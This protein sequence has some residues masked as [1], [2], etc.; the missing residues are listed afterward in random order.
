M[1]FKF[2]VLIILISTIFLNS[3]GAKAQTENQVNGISQRMI[4]P[5]Y[6][7]PSNK[8]AAWQRVIDSN[9]YK[10]IDVI[11]NPN[12]G[13]GSSIN[14]DYLEAIKK[15]K[16]GS[17]NVFG[18]VHTSYGDR[19]IDD[20]KKEID[21]WV[22]WYPLIDGIFID[23]AEYR[24]SQGDEPYYLEVYNYIK[25]KGLKSM[26]NPGTGTTESYISLADSTCIF[27]SAVSKAFVFP[28]W[29]YKYDSDKFCYLGHSA[30]LESMRSIVADLKIKKVK[31]V[32]I[33]DATPAVDFW[34]YLPSYLEEEAAL[35]YY[36]SIS[37]TNTPT[38]T[39]PTPSRTLTPTI[40]RTPTKTFTPIP[41][42]TF[43]KTPTL[44]LS[45]TPFSPTPTVNSTFWLCEQ[46]GSQMTCVIYP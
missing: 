46:Q 16:A 37:Q 24:A 27:E 31:N 42:K 28:S 43:T 7:Y 21:T 13:V 20:V 23:E 38:I 8:G 22:L 39:Q 41:T 6:I 32:Y 9:V 1:K 5:L 34:S 44:T 17:V 36:G 35:L 26:N 40:T 30:S 3:F 25:S 15:L 11:I 14:S 10:N 18:Y 29:S 19:N 45:S 2:S 33:T 12:S 4:I